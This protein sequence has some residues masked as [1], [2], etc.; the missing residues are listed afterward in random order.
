ME[1]DK[2]VNNHTKKQAM[3]LAFKIGFEGEASKTSCAQATFN[4][5]SSVL[6]VKNPQVFR[7]LYSLNGGGASST[8]G[9]CGA[10][11]GAMV[12]FSFFLGRT[13]EQWEEGKKGSRS[14]L[15]AHEFYKRFEK[16]FGTIIC[17]EIHKKLFGR[18]FDFYSRSDFEEF[19]KLGGHTTKCP[20]VVGLASAWAVE[21]LWD[22]IPEDPDISKII[23]MKDAF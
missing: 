14:A 23:D 5:I 19:E 7:S 3:E 16:K 18:T 15:L 8:C 4:A 1:T 12:S 2:K 21:I 22:H 11:S 10:F 9:S 13:Y 17:R 20:V 6:G